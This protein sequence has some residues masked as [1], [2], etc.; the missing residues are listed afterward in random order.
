[1]TA[2]NVKDANSQNMNASAAKNAERRPIRH[3]IDYADSQ[4]K[5]DDNDTI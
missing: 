2:R 3:V 5:D 1:M 4:C